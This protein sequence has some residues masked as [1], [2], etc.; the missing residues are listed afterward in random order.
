MIQFE[1]DKCLNKYNNQYSKKSA[2]DEALCNCS[3]SDDLLKES[4]KIKTKHEF[5]MS[6]TKPSTS[7]IPTPTDLNETLIFYQEQIYKL[8]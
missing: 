5:A 8:Q 2:R 4:P 3:Y 1:I 6:K 7:M